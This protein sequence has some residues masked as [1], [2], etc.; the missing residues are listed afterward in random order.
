MCGQTGHVAGLVQE[1]GDCVVDHITRTVDVRGHDRQTGGHPLEDGSRHPLRERRQCEHDG[2]GRMLTHI[3]GAES[4]RELDRGPQAKRPCLRFELDSPRTVSEKSQ[5]DGTT[6]SPQRRDR[7]EQI[8]LALAIDQTCGAQHDRVARTQRARPGTPPIRIHAVGDVL[9]AAT[10]DPGSREELDRS[11]RVGVIAADEAGGRS[12]ERDRDTA[13]DLVIVDVFGDVQ[14]LDPADERR[15]RIRDPAGTARNQRG[16]DSVGLD[17][18][19]PSRANEPAQTAS[20]R[21]AIPRLP[22]RMP[23]THE[24][25]S[26]ATIGPGG[27]KVATS[28]CTS[29]GSL[30]ARATT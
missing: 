23:G 26:R 27:K 9:D 13:L 16:L 20:T 10:G 8:R 2:L 7:L 5:L 17:H 11:L 3:C 22:T 29:V 15:R 25:R 24:D 19:E 6:L 21:D 18:V 30:S 4:S 1:P 12:F 14:S 28:H